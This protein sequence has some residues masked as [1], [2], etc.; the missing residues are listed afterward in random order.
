MTAISSLGEFGLI[1]HLTENIQIINKS[2]RKGIGDDAAVLEY[3]DKQVLVTTD[4]RIRINPASDGKY[5]NNK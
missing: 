1:R 4:R 2:T 5:S 3:N